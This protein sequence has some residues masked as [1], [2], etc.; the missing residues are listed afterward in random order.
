MELRG[1]PIV[2]LGTRRPLVQRIP[3]DVGANYRSHVFSQLPDARG[4]R[5]KRTRPFRP[6]ANGKAEVFN[7]LLQAEWAYARLYRSNEERLAAPLPFL[8]EYNH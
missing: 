1:A 4:T 7:K 5:P 6:Q 2:P 3:T 8:V